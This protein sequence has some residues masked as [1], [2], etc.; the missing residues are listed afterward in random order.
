MNTNVT[1]SALSWSPLRR[2]AWLLVLLPA[3][4]WAQPQALTLIPANGAVEVPRDTPLEI[5]FDRPVTAGLGHLQIIDF[6]WDELVTEI[7][8]SA[9]SIDGAHVTLT[10]PQ[11]LPFSRMIRI[12]LADCFLDLQGH[13]CEM[14]PWGWMFVPE[15]FG[16][17][18]YAPALYSEDASRTADLSLLFGRPIYAG[19]GTLEL[20]EL[21]GEAL[22]QAFPVSEW[23]ID[24]ARLTLPLAQP[25]AFGMDYFVLIP[26][27][28]LHDGAGGFFPGFLN[29]EDWLFRTEPFRIETCSPPDDAVD[30]AVDAAL[31]LVFNGDV[32]AGPGA[33][34]LRRADGSLVQSVPASHLALAGNRATFQPAA[35]L[36]FSTSFYVELDAD[37]FQAAAGGACA[38]LSGPA[39]WNFTTAA[40]FRDLLAGLPG[41]LENSSDWG[42]YDN[43][44]DLDLVLTG[45]LDSGNAA[46]FLYRNEGGAL[47]PV[48]SGIPGVYDGCVDWGDFDNDGDLDLLVTGDHRVAS[49][50]QPITRIYRNS[51]G[52]FS[53]LAAGLPDLQSSRGAWG[54]FDKDGDLDLFVTGA[55]SSSAISRI[56]RNDGETFT[57]VAAGLPGTLDGQGSWADV[58]NDGDLDLLLTGGW[59]AALARLYRNTNGSFSDSGAGLSAV[60][61]GRS[62]WGDFDND[63]DLD[64]LLT[65]MLSN[66]P[67]SRVYRNTGG[68]FTDMVAGLLGVA[69]NPSAWGDV[70]NDG[71]L[72][73]LLTGY[74]SGGNIARI[75]RNTG[76]VFSLEAATLP[77]GQ[78]GSASWADVDNDGDLDVLLAGGWGTLASRVLANQWPQANTP[79]LP[80]SSAHVTRDG[81][82]LQ[83]TWT[84]GADGQTP[85]AGLG[86]NVQVGLEGSPQLLVAG[87][88]DP[89]DGRRRVPGLG[90][91]GQRLAM[92]RAIPFLAEPLLPQERRALVAGVQAIDHTWAGSPFRWTALPAQGPDVYLSLH[93][94]H[95]MELD[96]L[97]RWEAGHHP[98]LAGYEVQLADNPGFLPV[99]G[100]TWREAA[101]EQ[102][103]L[104][105][106][107]LAELAG[108]ASLQV[109]PTY[110][111]RM[112]PVYTDA[113]RA[114]VFSATPGSFT[115]GTL[116]PAPQNLV[117]RVE[118]DNLALSWEPVPGA[119]VQYVVHVAD[120][121]LAPFP[122]G[123]QA[124]APTSATTWQDPLAGRERRFYRVQAVMLD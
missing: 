60:T 33:L 14:D 47:L 21:S 82:S 37:A 116:P 6:F 27:E 51:N 1:M 90:N 103:P 16:V 119:Q 11:P 9:A 49:L 72:D 2:G 71:D 123:W 56:Y 32:A 76:G 86:Y 26:R 87:M 52:I 58:D 55:A 46:L 112:R 48:E 101:G 67:S 81:S 41:L 61:H 84:A 22:V 96:S 64:L 89:V 57:D 97:L 117:A 13:P 15:S 110:Y 66:V 39:A 31:E 122:A 106:V 28:A 53:D 44:G 118:G 45:G 34:R 35:L 10:L 17:L 75:Y 5:L 24:G 12:T 63:G 43:D 120:D 83:V 111:W 104:A 8:A 88:A 62:S 77:G 91:A 20:R 69:N 23:E 105:G 36:D 98:E 54:D 7:P 95:P 3:L 50:T 93:N 18:E 94:A 92:D 108:A 29:V 79:P 30:V 70:D 100:Q 38:G 4:L 74:R 40:P 114:T 25:L 124:Q 109:G 113:R 107:P 102:E 68:V 99:L 73:I 19:T 121:P 78:S 80:P 85:A 59:S 115:L 42:D 65:G